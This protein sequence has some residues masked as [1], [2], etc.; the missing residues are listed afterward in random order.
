ME[1]VVVFGELPTTG[2]PTILRVRRIDRSLSTPSGVDPPG[3]GNQVDVPVVLV[4]VL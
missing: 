4:C 3:L 1:R 2:R